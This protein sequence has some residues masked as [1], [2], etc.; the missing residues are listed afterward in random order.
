MDRRVNPTQLPTSILF[1]AP[2]GTTSP[3]P[4]FQQKDLILQGL[5]F[6]LAYRF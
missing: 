2:D 4:T 5:N 6:G 1:G 3:A